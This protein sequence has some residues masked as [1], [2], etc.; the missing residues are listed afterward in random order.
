MQHADD[1]DVIGFGAKVDYMPFGVAP[2]QPWADL[3]GCACCFRLLAQ[4][5]DRGVQFGEVAISL[6]A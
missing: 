5:I 6:R 3:I 1:Q 4:R 2:K